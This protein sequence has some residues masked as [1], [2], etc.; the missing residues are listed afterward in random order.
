MSKTR[1]STHPDFVK[2]FDTTQLRNH[3]L[4]ETLFIP[5]EV[6]YTYTM[7][8]RMIIMGIQPVSRAI[9]LPALEEYTKAEFFLERRELGVINVGGPGLIKVDGEEF[10]IANL[11]C[12]YVGCGTKEVVFSSTDVSNP[13]EF[14]I[15]SLPAHTSY[16]TKKAITKDANQVVLGSKEN[17][18]ERVIYQY[19]HEDGIQS[20]QLVMGFTQL[21]PG[22]IWNTFPPHTHYRRMEAYF[23]FDLAENQVVM[24]FM[25]DPEET[26]HIVMK[27]KEAVISPEW[28]IHSG[29]GTAAYSFI[30]GMGGENKS[31]TDMDGVDLSKLK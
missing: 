21:K 13:A 30:W 31:F 9:S 17:C 4:I 15:N 12:L 3:F 24:H 6:E 8:D 5:D 26:R 29:V 2:T 22:S 7:H 25:G 18:N 11:D 1:F 23:Y 28:S 27:N 20:C 16:P 19:I 14:Y 10:T